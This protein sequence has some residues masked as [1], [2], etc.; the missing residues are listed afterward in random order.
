IVEG[1][2]QSGAG[3]ALYDLSSTGTLLYIP[4]PVGASTSS[5]NLA[6]VDRTGKGDIKPLNL[7]RGVYFYPRISPD[8]KRIAFGTS[9][10]KEAIIWI[11]DLSG[12]SSMRRL[13]FGGANRFPVWSRDGRYVAFQSDREG[14]LGIFWQLADG[15][16]AVE[17]LTTAEKGVS[18]IPDSWSFDG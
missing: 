15:T 2:R 11:Y 5:I 14:D 13:T 17:R 7:P 1:V 12:T 3:I 6:L 4:G 9:T 16:G 18:H 10:D 8:G